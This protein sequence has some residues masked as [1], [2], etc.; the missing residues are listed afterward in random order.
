MTVVGTV[1][2]VSLRDSVH[3]TMVL[4]PLGD[5]H[6]YDGPLNDPAVRLALKDL[7]SRSGPNLQPG[8]SNKRER[9]GDTYRRPDGTYYFVE[10]TLAVATECSL[11]RLPVGQPMSPPGS[12]RRSTSDVLVGIVHTH[13]TVYGNGKTPVYGCKD[14][15]TGVSLP[16]VWKG[17]DSEKGGASPADWK[18]LE[19]NVPGNSGSNATVAGYV[20]NADGEIWKQPPFLVPLSPGEQY[21]NKLVWNYQ[22][23]STPSCNW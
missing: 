3:L 12:L 22:G 16:L 11:D 14:P 15:I 23:N 2:G 8:D 21:K 17:K 4:C 6:E 9:G 19:R 18:F 10:D 20:I 13:P 7:M 5:G 1:D